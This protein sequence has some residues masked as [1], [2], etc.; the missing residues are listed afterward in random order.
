MEV[1]RSIYRRVVDHY[2]EYG[3]KSVFRHAFIL[4]IKR[5][6]RVWEKLGFYII[7]VHFYEP[8]PN[9]EYLIA[10]EDRIWKKSELAGVDMNDELQLKLCDAFSRYQNEWIELSKLPMGG[11][12]EVDRE[13]LFSM[14]RHFKPS[15]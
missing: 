4:A 8:I 1:K 11:F 2:K 13:V 5:N 14:V 10:N 9:T 12:G 3:L 6:F 7:P 15:K